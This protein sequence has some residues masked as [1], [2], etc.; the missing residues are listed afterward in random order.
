M[1][2]FLFYL[3][4]MVASQLFSQTTYRTYKVETSV[5]S[6]SK[7]IRN[8]SEDKWDFI[9][10]DKFDKFKCL[11]VFYIS[12]E[13]TGTITNGDVNYD[14]LSYSQIDENMVKIKV[15]NLKVSREVDLVMMKKNEE[16]T[17]AI[18]DY[19]ERTGYYFLP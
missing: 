13:N 9:M 6:T 10:S 12:D 5:I 7:M 16:M 17:I 8:Y 3:L 15:Y 1:K 14:I 4:C 2:K 18:Y 19:K 11:W